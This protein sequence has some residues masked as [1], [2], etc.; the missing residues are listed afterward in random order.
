MNDIVLFCFVNDFVFGRRKVWIITEPQLFYV[1]AEFHDL[2][3]DVDIF[4]GSLSV[5]KHQN[6]PGFKH[7]IEA[8]MPSQYPEDLY[9]NKFWWDTLRCTP[10]L[11]LYCGKYIS[12]PPNISLE[13]KQEEKVVM[14]TSQPRV[15]IWN[16]VHAVAHALH[17]MLL[18]KTEI[19]PHK[20]EN[21]DRF[22]PWQV[23]LPHNQGKH[24]ALTLL[25][26]NSWYSNT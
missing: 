15:S 25:G 12:C 20:A 10:L 9:F 17:K 2:N 4:G 21:K 24:W 7:F 14:I 13:T 5:S 8:L 16:A 18:S 23:S 11:P 26:S 19:A 6:I 3:D 1:D 22:L